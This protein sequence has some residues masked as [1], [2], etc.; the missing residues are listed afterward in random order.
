MPAILGAVRLAAL[1]MGFLGITWL[2]VIGVIFLLQTIVFLHTT[3]RGKHIVWHRL[4]DDLDL[5]G[6]ERILDVG[7]GRGAVLIAAG[8]HG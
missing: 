3:L 1:V 5:G 6:D 4:L 7:C 2:M 8:G